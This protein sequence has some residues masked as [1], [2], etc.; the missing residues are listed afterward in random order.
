[1]EKARIAIAE[2]TSGDEQRNRYRYREVHR[3]CVAETL[4]QDLTREFA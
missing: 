1:M 3:K 2:T 4:N